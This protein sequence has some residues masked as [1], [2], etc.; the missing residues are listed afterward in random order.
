MVPAVAVFAENQQEGYPDSL[1]WQG[2]SS[3]S[4]DGDLAW[5][6]PMGF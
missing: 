5:F 4:A 3:V 6:R 1:S 2:P